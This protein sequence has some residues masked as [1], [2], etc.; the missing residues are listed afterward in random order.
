MFCAMIESA[1][2]ARVA[3]SSWRSA[4]PMAARTSGGRSVDVRVMRSTMLS[5]KA[6]SIWSS[7]IRGSHEVPCRARSPRRSPG[8]RR[9]V[10]RRADAAGG[11][12]LPHQ[13]PCRSA[14]SLSSPRSRSRRP[15]PRPTRALGRL[16]AEIAAAI[17]RAADDVLAGKL[18]DQFVV[19]IYQAGAGTSHNMNTNEVLANRA[20]EILGGARGEY[21]RVHPNDHVNMGQSTNDV[22]PDRDA[23]RDHEHGA[24]P[25]LGRQRPGQRPCLPRAPSSRTF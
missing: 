4:R 25:A 12:E 7:I 1:W 9:C 11:R 13:R 24:G 5:R 16:P 17:V 2:P 6:G 3:G 20:A 18:R 23:P 8:A 19:D 10:L 15:P 14:P 21:S 22:Y